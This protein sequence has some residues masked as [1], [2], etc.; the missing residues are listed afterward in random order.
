VFL[1]TQRLKYLSRISSLEER[2]GQHERRLLGS[3]SVIFPA[4]QHIKIHLAGLIK[5]LDP[6]VTA[7][8]SNFAEMG[9][10]VS[11]MSRQV[12]ELPTKVSEIHSKVIEHDLGGSGLV[13]GSGDVRRLASVSH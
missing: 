1:G 3:E 6:K 5:G 9:T 7:L 12:G 13:F 11:E 4:L 10:K 2:A 8:A